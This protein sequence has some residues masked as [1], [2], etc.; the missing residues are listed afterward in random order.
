MKQYLDI[1][2]KLRKVRN[3]VVDEE[4]LTVDMSNIRPK[5][6]LI[7]GQLVNS[8]LNIRHNMPRINFHKLKVKSKTLAAESRIIRE[9]ERKTFGEFRDTLYLHRVNVV[10]DE[11]RTTHI[12]I[13]FLKGKKYKTIESSRRPEKEYNF[14][15]LILK[16]AAQI[17]R[18]YSNTEYS[19]EQVEATLKMW[20]EEK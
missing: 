19:A 12:A 11:A 2:R 17:I 7:N 4:N 5:G 15:Y 9:E 16:R 3:E 18:K 6:E 8:W 20:V 10:R 1:L 14:N 13:T